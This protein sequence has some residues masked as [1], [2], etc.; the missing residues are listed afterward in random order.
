MS[1]VGTLFLYFKPIFMIPN[2]VLSQQ[3]HVKPLKEGEIAVFKLIGAGEIDP[4]TKR[5]RTKSFYNIQGEEDVFDRFAK[6]IVRIANV[7]GYTPISKDGETKYIPRSEDIIVDYTNTFQCTHQNQ[8][9]YQFLMRSNKNAKNPYADPNVEKT[10]YLANSNTVA[11]ETNDLDSILINIESV[12]MT[13]NQDQMKPVFR[14]ILPQVDF[15]KLGTQQMR[16][17]LRSMVKSGYHQARRVGK[18]LKIQS[19]QVKDIQNMINIYDA[20]DAR[21]LLWDEDKNQWFFNDN[22]VTPIME[23]DRDLEPVLA[24]ASFLKTKKGEEISRALVMLMEN[25]I[26]IEKAAK[27]AVDA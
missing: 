15:D 5:P 4:T 6:K 10:F 11:R 22:A 27:S 3:M 1:Y 9:T 19:T 2:E 20:R 21:Y 13:A 8:E 24:L 25:K 23:V 14:E 18:A 12:V 17:R 26:N 7:V 16:A